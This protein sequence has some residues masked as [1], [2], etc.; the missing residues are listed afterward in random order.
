M[1]DYLFSSARI[2]T[3]ESQLVTR[4]RTEELLE[5]KSL[6]EAF[7]RLREYGIDPVTDEN[8][9]PL[10][11]DTLLSILRK[12]YLTVEEMLPDD[13]A[14]VLWRY[15]YDCNNI[16]AA[17]KGFARKIDP[18]T[19]MFDFGTVDIDSVI[20]M[21]ETGCFDGLPTHMKAV[22]VSAT[23]EYAKTKDPQVIDLMLDAAC[24]AD[25][26][27]AATRSGV[28]FAVQLV[29]MK[30]DL[31]NLLICVRILR[32]K[33]GEMGRLL[34][35]NALIAGGLI[36][37]ADLKAWFSVGEDFLWD[38][39][40]YSEYDAL[41]SAVSASDGSLTAVERCLDNEWMRQIRSVKFVSYGAEVA[42]A[43]LQAHE[44]EVRNLRIILSGKEAGLA[45]ETLR[46]RIRD[47][48]V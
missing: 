12:S 38:R 31:T 34:L 45:T 8:G 27:E 18:R 11:E 32:M 21:T 4:A 13:A 15:P 26:L 20:R 46:E 2:R 5:A 10:R 29:R 30:I 9:K 43:F 41:A 19:M 6:A 14:L 3:L 24:Y 39:L 33:S 23:E 40:Y 25:M 44:Y 35:E 22:A 48:Y 17:I 42:I 16:K 47:S 36:S 1:K 28:A 37:F 7:D